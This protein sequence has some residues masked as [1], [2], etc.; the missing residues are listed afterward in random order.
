AFAGHLR[1]WHLVNGSIAATDDKEFDA[2]EGLVIK[3]RVAPDGHHAVAQLLGNPFQ[4]DLHVLDVDA[5]GWTDRR[6]LTVSAYQFDYVVHVVQGSETRL[7]LNADT[8]LE[9]YDIT[10]LQPAWS[11]STT[12]V[13]LM[14]TDDGTTLLLRAGNAA[15]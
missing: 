6:T 1:F 13:P 4:S 11:R 12:E 8:V 14:T 15:V 5:N 9:S 2:A 7:T 10:S 3:I